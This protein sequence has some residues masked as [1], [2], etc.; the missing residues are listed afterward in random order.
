M[1]R[2]EFRFAGSSEWIASPFSAAEDVARHAAR[3]HGDAQVGR[4]VRELGRKWGVVTFAVRDTP[5]ARK[6]VTVNVRESVLVG[7]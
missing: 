7:T 5:R 1:A 3:L 6:S 4:Y 2:F